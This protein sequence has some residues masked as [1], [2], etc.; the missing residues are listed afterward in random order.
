MSMLA[1]TL[2]LLAEN[3]PADIDPNTGRGAEWGK[4]APV[5]LL[6][7]LLMCVATFFIL[8][9]FARNMRKVPASFDPP[10][11][12]GDVEAPAQLVEANGEVPQQ[13][14]GSAEQNRA[15]A[16]DQETVDRR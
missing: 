5:G 9:S 6:V 13:A 10:E 14:D 2:I 3:P 11:E 12:G 1:T 8:R 15:E 16:G 7:L 4:A